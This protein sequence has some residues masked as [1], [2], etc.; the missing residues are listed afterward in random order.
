VWHSGLFDYVQAYPYEAVNL[1]A[2]LFVLG[3]LVPM[4]R[5]LGVGCG[6]FVGAS[7]VVPL[8]FGGLMGIGRFTSV[9][10]PVFIWLATATRSR[11]PLLLGVFAVL[12]GL[13]TALFFTDRP[14]F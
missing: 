3:A 10:F 9:M 12:Q 13:L 11:T 1:L 6:L 14:I 8:S 5:R 2:A 7:L 4:T